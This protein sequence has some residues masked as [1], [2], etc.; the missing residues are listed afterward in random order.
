MQHCGPAP[1]LAWPRLSGSLCHESISHNVI[2]TLFPNPSHSCSHWWKVKSPSSAIRCSQ[3]NLSKLRRRTFESLLFHQLPP[4]HHY[5]IL[6]SPLFLFSFLLHIMLPA[7]STRWVP[8]ILSVFWSPCLPSWRLDRFQILELNI[9]SLSPSLPDGLCGEEAWIE[10]E[11]PPPALQ[12][13][14]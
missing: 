2:R 6:G 13:S 8:D 1:I 5:Y 14:S 12:L 11:D 10:Y 3:V 4:H 9:P 7:V